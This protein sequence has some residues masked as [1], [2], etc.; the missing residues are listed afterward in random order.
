MKASKLSKRALKADVSS[1]ILEE[2][3]AYASKYIVEVQIT[4]K[5]N[6][7]IPMCVVVSDF[8]PNES[9]WVDVAIPN[10][11]GASKR[12]Q[13]SDVASFVILNPES[14]RGDST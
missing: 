12:I 9:K 14:G 1:E 7:I 10:A 6:I 4:L 8:D 5:S 11:H 13:V 3:I 2:R